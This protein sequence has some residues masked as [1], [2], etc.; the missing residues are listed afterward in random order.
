MHQSLEA[1]TRPEKSGGLNWLTGQPRPLPLATHR[2]SLFKLPTLEGNSPPTGISKRLSMQ[3]D[4]PFQ[5]EPFPRRAE[6]QSISIA[7]DCFITRKFFEW[8][9]V[10][11][12]TCESNCPWAGG[13]G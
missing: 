8:A 9:F 1:N 2:N 12:A 13:T 3:A 6:F 4:Q 5:P 7:Q 10:P 11:G